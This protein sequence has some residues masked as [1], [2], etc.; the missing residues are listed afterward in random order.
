VHLVA[1][2]AAISETGT[3]S[4]AARPL[5]PGHCSFYEKIEKWEELREKARQET[6]SV[7][8]GMPHLVNEENAGHDLSLPLL[9]PL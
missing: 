4:N 6:G 5:F 8:I 2:G 3:A 1:R 9:S 7:G